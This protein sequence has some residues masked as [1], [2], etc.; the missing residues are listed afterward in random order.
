MR[1]TK[2]I[3]I[4]FLLILFAV[5]QL[6]ATPMGGIKKLNQVVR[7]AQNFYF[8]DFDMD[9]AMEGAI[10]G[11]LEA[12]DPHS[13]Y[14]DAKEFKTIN[15]QFEGNFQGIGIEYSML[16]GYITVISPI[17]ETPSE[18]AGLQSGDKIIKIDGESAYKITTE[19]V[20]KKLRGEKG[21]TV[22]I[23]ILRDDMEPFDVML[24]RDEI[25]IKSIIASFLIK[26]EIGYVKINRFAN[27]TVEE[28]ESALNQLEQQGMNKLILDL[29]NNGG[30]LLGQAVDMVDLFVSSRDTIVYTRGKISS[31][32][33]VYYSRNNFYDKSYELVVLINNGSASA[34][35]IVSGALQD[36]DRA[37]IFGE[38]SFGKGLVQRQIPLTD[39]SAAR[40]TIAQYFTPS[41][42]LIQRPY[43]KGIDQ[44]YEI[45]SIEDTSLTNKSIHYT[46]NGRIVYGGGGIW[47]DS[48]IKYDEDFINFLKNKLRTN[49]KRPFF[50]Y[51]N[52][53]K[54]EYNTYLNQLTEEDFYNLI[55]EDMRNKNEDWKQNGYFKSL[56]KLDFLDW[57]EQEK[58]EYD[59]ELVIRDWRYIKINIYAEVANAK[60][61]KNIS[62]KIKSLYDKQIVESIN[63]L[64]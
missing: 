54:L 30:G 63:Y 45:E 2:Y 52:Q 8:E 4:I 34:S 62:Y 36:L 17:P 10:R 46:K 19:E 32:N 58:I 27:N 29:R 55:K 21:T 42:R 13:Q 44:Y 11:F 20:F 3:I 7:L 24:I 28:L 35:E 61:G 51:G 40:I 18:R 43:N 6:G 14:I 15:E 33:E 23:Q 16:D 5:I 48:L 47:P 31:A 59:K 39:G 26:P 38:R 25:P 50:K 53:L 57:L 60:W 64:K 12:L 56:N 49:I 22:T 9:K 37:T 41:G 1:K